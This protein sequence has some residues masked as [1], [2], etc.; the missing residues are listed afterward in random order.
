MKNDNTL[1]LQFIE[2]KIANGVTN[3]THLANLFCTENPGIYRTTEACRSAI[4]YMLGVSGDKSRGYK[5]LYGDV[6]KRYHNIIER[7]GDKPHQLDSF[8]KILFFDLETSPILAYTW[9]LYNQNI[10]HDFIIRD[11]FLLT[12]SAKWFMDKKIMHD[13]LTSEEAIKGNDKRI[14]KSLWALIDEADIIVAHNLRDFDEKKMNQRFIINGLNPPSPYQTFDTLQH[15][16]RN[17]KFSSNKL[18]YINNV[19]GISRKIHTDYTLWLRCLRGEKK[20]FKEMQDYN[21][22]DVIC[23]EELYLYMR[24]WMKSHPNIGVFMDR[25]EGVC[26]ICGSSKVNA[27]GKEYKTMVGSFSLYKCS[28]CGGYS[29]GRT[30]NIDK[31]VKK[32]MNTSIAR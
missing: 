27:I 14:T 17:F 9:G 16:R 5:S 2:N 21:D 28:H 29:R 6:R 10:N 7:N 26:A 24:P 8:P 1:L 20:A 31:D 15:A 22:Q 23:L 3:K 4:K 25:Y 32:W 12:W 19:L 11:W 18:D 13:S 30:S